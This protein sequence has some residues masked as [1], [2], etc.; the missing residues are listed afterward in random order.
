MLRTRL[1]FLVSHACLAAFVMPSLLYA[2]EAQ[3]SARPPNGEVKKFVF[4]HSKVFPG[5][6]RDYWIYVPRQYD[7]A[8]PACLYVNQSKGQMPSKLR[9]DPHRHGCDFKTR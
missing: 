7:P 9:S 4:D 2:G 3:T 8:R 5:T 1:R 6:V